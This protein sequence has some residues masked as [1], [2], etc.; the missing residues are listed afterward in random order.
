ME[1]A[2]YG[3]PLLLCAALALGGCGGAEPARIGKAEADSVKLGTPREE[4]EAR[5]GEPE[6]DVADPSVNCLT[7]IS[8]DLKR[9]PPREHKLPL[10]EQNKRE[11]ERERA[12]TEA[13]RPSP[14]AS[15]WQLCFNL[16]TKRLR[17]V[18]RDGILVR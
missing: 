6:R 2:P 14:G 8:R 4:V 13:E 18:A 5:L 16:K 12:R 10:L 3:A 15:R 1:G 17:S 7:Y 11:E 9:I